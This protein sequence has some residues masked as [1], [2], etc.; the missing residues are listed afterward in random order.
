MLVISK[1]EMTLCNSA[2]AQGG[3][4]GVYKNPN[5]NPELHKHDTLVAGGYENK[6][7][8]LDILVNEA[9]I[10]IGKII[11]LG[12]DFDKT[13][14]GDYHRTLEGGHGMHRIFHHKDTTGFEILS[15]LLR[16][17]QALPNVDIIENS[18]I[19]DLKK[20]ENGFSF[21]VLQNDDHVY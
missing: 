14:D 16:T 5:D 15:T 6:V 20:T 7:D 18:V 1:R 21:D 19:C 11:E 4:A 13:P 10:D 17:V 12:V 8:A 2:L 3:I 9:K